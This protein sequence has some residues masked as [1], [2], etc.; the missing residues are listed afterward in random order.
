VTAGFGDRTNTNEA[1]G[2]SKGPYDDLS[3]QLAEI[4]RPRP[5]RM[6]RRGK[7][8][9]G[10]VSIALLASLGIF[11]A[12][13]VA[14]SA[15]GG[16]NARQPQFLTF[17]LPIILVFVIVPL[18]LRTIG[19]QKSLLAEGEMAMARVTKRWAARN[20]PNINYEFTTPLG[21][22]FSRSAADGSGRLSVGMNVPIFYDPQKPKKQL[23]L[24][25]SFYEVILQGEN[26]T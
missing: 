13:L 2:G 10:A 1:P 26:E 9:A 25:A 16:R 4:P 3:R 22:H 20:G 14:T 6:S 11:A 15:A 24:S 8:T 19:K 5:V 7:L 17:A 12:G 23:A 18:M 21:E